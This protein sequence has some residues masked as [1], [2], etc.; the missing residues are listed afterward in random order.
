MYMGMCCLQPGITPH[1]RIDIKV[2][3]LEQKAFATLYFTGSDHFNRSMRQFAKLAGRSLSDHGLVPVIRDKQQYN[4]NGH[5]KDNIVLT[6]E[7]IQCTSEEEIFQ[8]LGME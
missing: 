3:P 6:G 2:Y 4:P 8:F 5:Y 1:R 7:S